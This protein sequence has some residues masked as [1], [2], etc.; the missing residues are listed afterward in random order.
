MYITKEEC[1]ILFCCMCFFVFVDCYLLFF[2]YSSV[3]FTLSSQVFKNNLPEKPIFLPRI[4]FK[5]LRLNL[6][7]KNAPRFNST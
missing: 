6:I 3:I 7:P 5:F 4:F 1:V 2:I